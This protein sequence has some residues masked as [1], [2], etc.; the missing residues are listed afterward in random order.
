MVPASVASFASIVRARRGDGEDEGDDRGGG[1]RGH[2][3][4]YLS[5]DSDAAAEG[6][7]E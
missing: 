4:G 7:K 5:C 3:I 6:R 1:L 2:Y